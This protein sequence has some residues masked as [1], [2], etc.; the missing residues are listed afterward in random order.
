MWIENAHSFLERWNTEGISKPFLENGHWVVIAP[1]EHPSAAG[2]LGS[3]LSTAALGSAFR[4][5]RGLRI[6]SGDKAL[7]SENRKVLTALLDKRMPWE[8]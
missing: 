7:R 8:I 6:E 4:E 5:L 2:L 1:R 3:K